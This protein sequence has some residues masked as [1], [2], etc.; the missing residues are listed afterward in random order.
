LPLATQVL[1]A[2]ELSTLEV[3]EL[4][5]EFNAIGLTAELRQVPPRR[6]LEDI[7]W[8]A[9]AVAPLKPFFEQ[10]VKDSAD[11]AYQRLKAFA[12]KLYHRDKQPSTTHP[13]VLLLEDQTTGIQVVLEADLPEEAYRQLLSFDLNTIRRGPLHY[14]R[15]R[16]RWRSELDEAS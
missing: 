16:H 6:T 9:L 4:V 3:T 12:G 10:L 13:K 5:E 15:Y 1:F 2:T 11:D 14:D 8:L 7:A